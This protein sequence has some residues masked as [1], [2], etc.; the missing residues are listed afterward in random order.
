VTANTAAAKQKRSHVDGR[1]VEVQ[2]PPL[3][4]LE[5]AQRNLTDTVAS[6]VAADEMQ[7]PKR[8][9]RGRSLSSVQLI[10]SITT[11][12]EPQTP[13]TPHASSENISEA[14]ERHKELNQLARKLDFSDDENVNQ[15]QRQ[16]HQNQLSASASAP[17]P[18]HQQ[19]PHRQGPAPAGSDASGHPTSGVPS[20]EDIGHEE[21]KSIQAL[22]STFPDLTVD[23][24]RQ[25][26]RDAEMDVLRALDLVVSD[27]SGKYPRMAPTKRKKPSN[28]NDSPIEPL[29]PPAPSLAPLAST[30]AAALPASFGHP[31]MT[32]TT[33]TSRT[34]SVSPAP[35]LQQGG[36]KDARRR[37]PRTLEEMLSQDPQYAS[38]FQHVEALVVN[39]LQYHKKDLSSSD[40]DR[41]LFKRTWEARANAVHAVRIVCSRAVLNLESC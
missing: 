41:K 3:V 33:P 13:K 29:R 21:L 9:P 12:L 10:S 4:V 8:S 5:E 28:P 38:P 14:A 6:A 19:Q 37:A 2:V 23:G 7:T 39:F 25:A 31:P 18:V 22:E 16:Q 40:R 27:R 17:L 35:W 20:Y 26:L 15:G 30:P 34:P 32:P 36:T 11:S 24:A 1:Q